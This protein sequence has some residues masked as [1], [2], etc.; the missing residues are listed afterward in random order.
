MIRAELEKDAHSFS[1][2]VSGHAGYGRRGEDTVCA[3]VSSL[4]HGLVSYVNLLE[5]QGLARSPTKTAA[6]PGWAWIYLCPEPQAMDNAAG[7]FALAGRTL[8][9]LGEN[10]PGNIQLTEKRRSKN[11]K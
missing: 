8:A 1:L 7:A 9:L 5:R 4:I 3:A 11:D 2:R 10:F 6:E